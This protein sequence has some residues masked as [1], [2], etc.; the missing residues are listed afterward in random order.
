MSTIIASRGVIPA[1][2][3]ITDVSGSAVDGMRAVSDRFAQARAR[4]RVVAAMRSA[5]RRRAALQL[6]AVYRD[7][8]SVGVFGRF[9]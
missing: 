7:A 9:A 4:R 5:R 3:H 1:H 6:L 2:G 8:S